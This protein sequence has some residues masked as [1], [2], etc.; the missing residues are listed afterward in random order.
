MQITAISFRP[1]LAFGH[2]GGASTPM[3]NYV[4]RDDPTIHGSG[5]T[6]IEPALTLQVLADGSVFPATPT[7]L[8]FR[9]NTK[10]RPTAPFFEL[11]AAVRFD[12]DD[13]G[14]QPGS[15]AEMPLTGELLQAAGGQLSD[16]AYDVTVGNRKAARRTLDD[17]NAFVATVQVRGDDFEQHRLLASSPVLSGATPLVDPARPIPLGSFRVIRPVAGQVNAVDRD[18]LRV[19]FTPAAGEVYGPPTAVTGSD[20]GKGP[21]VIVQPA[22]RILNEAASWVTYIRGKPTDPQPADTYDGADQGNGNDQSLGVVDDTCDGL[23]TASLALDGRTLSASCRI[24]V[25]P[26]DFAPDRRPFVSLADDLADRDREPLDRQQLLDDGAATAHRFADLFQRVWETA[27]LA[28]LDA[29]RARALEENAGDNAGDQTPPRTDEFSMRYPEDAP[30]ADAKVEALIPRELPASDDLVF[31]KLI[32]QAHETLADE[33]SFIEFVLSQPMRL[34]QLI[35]PAYG[36][37]HQ[38]PASVPA[39]ATPNDS[40]R[41]PRIARDRMHDMRM[42]P[43]MRDDIA[44]ALALTWRQFQELMSY[45]DIALAA[46]GGKGV[47]GQELM[48]AGIDKEQ[49]AAIVTA[50]RRR[51]Q[52]RLRMIGG[53][54]Q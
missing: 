51:M 28:N 36:A 47:G 10:L 15:A 31:T 29:I 40:F 52:H 35:R 24:C 46:T 1:P 44:Q 18:I 34:R 12:A 38:L 26:P 54:P 33:D 21:Y 3:D 23:I 2:L 6:V 41:D 53:I 20:H 27:S 16:L 45:V 32:A 11:W 37:F 42:P 5:R 17:S 4:W 9:E 19:R 39:N 8:R 30:Y 49:P 25:S 13:A 22:N 48:A 50:L 7:V 14:H 43:Y